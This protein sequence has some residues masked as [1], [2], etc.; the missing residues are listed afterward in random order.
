MR[1][2]TVKQTSEIL[3]VSEPTVYRWAKLMYIPH[4]RFGRMIRF[5]EGEIRRWADERRQT[6]EAAGRIPQ[7][8]V[9]GGVPGHGQAG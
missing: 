5:E 7:G 8:A 9:S 4:H 1:F 2:L 3:A 6:H